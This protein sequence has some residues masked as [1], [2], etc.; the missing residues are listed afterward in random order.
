MKSSGLR[1]YPQVVPQS[2]QAAAHQSGIDAAGEIVGSR[3]ALGPHRQ[4][5]KRENA[6]RRRALDAAAV[7]FDGGRKVKITLRER[8]PESIG[9][10]VEQTPNSIPVMPAYGH[11]PIRT[12]IVG[13][14]TS[15]R[16]RKVHIAVLLVR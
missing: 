1:G 15:A 6:D 4:G 12:L 2:L 16:I 14:T 11:S 3:R 7:R 5:R 13:S 9:G 8:K 10:I